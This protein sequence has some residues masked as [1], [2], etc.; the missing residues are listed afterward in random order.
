MEI[1][2]K[3]LFALLLALLFLKPSSGATQADDPLSTIV[4]FKNVAMIHR[5]ADFQ[6][7]EY[8]YGLEYFYR[9]TNLLAGS[10][11]T[12]IYNHLTETITRLPVT[13]ILST[14]QD[15]GNFT[16]WVAFSDGSVCEMLSGTGFQPL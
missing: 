13:M 7:L 4:Q 8:N 6:I 11:D 10:T 12:R 15:N 3:Y 2:M 14:N 16:L 9:E 1:K 5:C